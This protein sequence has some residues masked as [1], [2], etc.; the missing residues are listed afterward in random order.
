[1]YEMLE[2]LTY[3]V[4]AMVDVRDS[5][6]QRAGKLGEKDALGKRLKDLADAVEKLRGSIVATKESAGITGE[7]KLREKLGSLYGGVNGYDG[8]PTGS[9]LERVGVLGKELDTAIASFQG[10]VSKDLGPVNILLEKRKLEAIKPLTEA[11]WRKRQ[12]KT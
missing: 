12:E 9:Q 8:R 7:E 10:I 5:A 1:L 11:E 4:D 3:N 6:R 2:H